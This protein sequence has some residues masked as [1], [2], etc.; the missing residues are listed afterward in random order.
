MNQSLAIA[1]IQSVSIKGNI[2]ANAVRHAH[3]AS[4]AAQ[5][6]AKFVLFPELSLTGY[7]LAIARDVAIRNDDP[8]LNEL[9][10]L[11]KEANI[12]IVAGAPTIGECGNLTIAALAFG[13]DDQL[14]VYTK[15]HLHSGEA[16]IFI[17]G[18]GGKLLDVHGIKFAL[19][20]CADISQ[21]CH[22]KRAAESCASVYA[23]SVLV[24]D[25]GYETDTGLLRQYAES[26][27][28]PVVMANHGAMTGGWKS[29]GRSAIWDAAGK[30]IVAAPADGECIVMA[31]RENGNWNSQVLS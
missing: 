13:P 6:G 18:D 27:A 20:V 5:R 28:M 1:A 19:A 14:S 17:P 3:L 2:A 4:A 12:T 15:Q 21:P 9:R 7:E 24:T 11:A 8:R 16:E 22:P 30:L 29:A 31:K 23:A 25:N 26:Y 10:R